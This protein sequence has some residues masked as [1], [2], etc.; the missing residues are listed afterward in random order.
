MQNITLCMRTWCEVR[1]FA[2]QK[3]RL[4]PGGLEGRV[5]KW[6]TWI[7]RGLPAAQKGGPAGCTRDDH[8]PVCRLDI[9]QDSEFATGYG[10]PKT[11]FK[12]EPDTD[13]DI[14]NAF[15]DVSR[16]HTFGKSCTL[17]D[18]SFIIF[19]SIFSAFCAMTPSLSALWCNLCTVM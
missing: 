5:A 3:F 4:I 18:Q 13:P 17:H 10:Y 9:R 14:R 1:N 16:I 7:F 12:W 15:T 19:R 11:A 2:S 6:K 8:Y